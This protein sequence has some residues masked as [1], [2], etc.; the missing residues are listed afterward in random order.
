MHTATDTPAWLAI[1]AGGFIT[2]NVALAIATILYL[3]ATTLTPLLRAMPRAIVTGNIEAPF[4]PDTHPRSPLI[5]GPV[6]RHLELPHG[7]ATSAALAAR[8]GAWITLTALGVGAAVYAV[9][10]L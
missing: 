7:P 8:W 10:W 4:R 5:A 9:G 3:A 6:L 1:M 2:L